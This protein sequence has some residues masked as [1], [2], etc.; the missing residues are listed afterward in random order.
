MSTIDVEAEI[1][2]RDAA[3]RLLTPLPGEC[4]ACYENRMLADFGCD[5][6]LRF[7]R[8]YRD[9]RAPR[10]TALERTLGD[11]GGY[12]DCEV[13]WNVFEVARELWTPE[14]WEA[15]EDGEGDFY[16][17]AEP[18]DQI[19]ACATVRGGST[20]PCHWWQRQRRPRW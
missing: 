10:A 7:A 12:C 13:L 8:A 16:I 9:E 15:G 4:L 11:R 3:S 19:P 1:V 18:P 2:L 20:Q 5:N 17:E 14:R 6:T